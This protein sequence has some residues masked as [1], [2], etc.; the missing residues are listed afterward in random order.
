MELVRASS[1]FDCKAHTS[2]YRDKLPAV[3]TEIRGI[4]FLLVSGTTCALPS[5]ATS[6][7]VA[8]SALDTIVS[9]LLSKSVI[10][11]L[12]IGAV[13]VLISGEFTAGLT[14]SRCHILETVN[15][16]T[17]SAS[18]ETNAAIF[19][20]TLNTCS[21]LERLSGCGVLRECYRFW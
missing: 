14:G 10:G 15:T 3:P 9:N 5:M 13:V 4:A 19:I 18:T 17:A 2:S 11:T 8:A 21:A 16:T 1:H 7:S 12:P 20:L 6:V